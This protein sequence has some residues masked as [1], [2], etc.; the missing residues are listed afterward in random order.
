MHS[1]SAMMQLQRGHNWG[2]GG[3]P[4][5][6]HII[7]VEGG[8]SS[9]L[10]VYGILATC[11]CCCCCMCA[12]V[13]HCWH[14]L[15]KL[16]LLYSTCTTYAVP[17]HMTPGCPQHSTVLHLQNSSVLRAECQMSHDS[18]TT[19]QHVCVCGCGCLSL[20]RVPS[21]RGG[22]LPR[23]GAGSAA[24]AGAPRQGCLHRGREGGG[25]GGA[26]LRAHHTT[27]L[28]HTHTL[29]VHPHPHPLTHHLLL[30]SVY[31]YRN[32]G[33]RRQSHS[34]SHSLTLTHMH[35]HTRTRTCAYSHSH[36]HTHTHIH[37]HSHT[38]THTYAHTHHFQS[39]KTHQR[40]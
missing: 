1:V 33:R 28:T 36:T 11:C 15:Y 5:A 32:R 9:T 8:G 29:T 7:C 17:A 2:R 10:L 37:A 22:Q 3:G 24:Q 38:C 23:G 14:L 21:E 30:L 16:V 40:R 4:L 20:C 26:R 12:I 39:S 25:R 13:L 19:L 6:T 27:L 18:I 35:T 31:S 34:T